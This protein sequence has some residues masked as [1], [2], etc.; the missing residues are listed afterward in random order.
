MKRILILRPVFT[1][2]DN[3]LYVQRKF[4]ARSCNHCCSGKTIIIRP[5]DCV[6]VALDIQHAM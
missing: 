2:T 5:P 3:E 1:K 4:G 6:F